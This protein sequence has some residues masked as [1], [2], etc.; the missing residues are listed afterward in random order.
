MFGS[1]R[2]FDARGRVKELLP[3]IGNSKHLRYLNLSHSGFK[4]LPDSICN[5]LNLQTLILEYCLKLE[6]FPQNMMYLRS[7]RHLFLSGY[8]LIEMP[9]KLGQLTNLKTLNKFVVGMS[10]D[11]SLLAELKCLKL[12]G[13]LCIWHLERV[14]NP[15]AAKEAN[16]VG[17]QNLREEGRELFPRLREI[18]IVYCPKLSFPHLS[19]PKELSLVGQCTMVVNSISNLNGL[20]SLTIGYDGETVCFPKE[21]LRNLTLLESLV[22]ENCHQLKLLPRD[23]ASLVTLKSLKIK[24]CPKLE[25][26]PEEGLRGLES[27]QSLHIINCCEL[28]RRCEEGKGE[29]WYKIAHIPKITIKVTLDEVFIRGATANVPMPSW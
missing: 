29:D 6:R 19:A 16:L 11:C 22:I 8:Q 13:E 20:T 17:M 4:R 14:R 10:T 12:Q 25:S 3:P 24:G 15:M 21:F 9:P 2:A 28:E 26:L 7:L 23:L 18:D 27:L 1:L 5:L